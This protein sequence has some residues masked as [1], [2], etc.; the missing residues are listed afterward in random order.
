MNSSNKHPLPGVLIKTL[1][2]SG[3]IL[4]SF[5]LLVLIYIL[6]AYLLARIPVDGDSEQGND[7]TVYLLT[8]G[9]H[10]DI[11]VP[12]KTSLQDWTTEVKYADTRSNDTSNQFLAMGWGDK[13]FYLETPTW[14]D[15]KASVAFKAAT[16]LS[17]TAIHATFHKELRPGDSCRKINITA[18]Q[19]RK[20]IGYIKNSF[21]TDRSGHFMNIKTN[22]NYGDTDAF[23]EAKGSYS[24]FHTCNSWVNN[25]LKAS[26]LK[27]CVWTPFDTGLFLL[28]P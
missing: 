8:N 9:V 20:L 13:G 3:L 1:R 12:A 11:V 28:Y 10:T 24:M 23:Y 2:I 26:G 27:S 4:T 16:G 19:Y 21:K 7:I 25:A 6:L 17:T 18:D 22:A 5:M 14:A 15:L